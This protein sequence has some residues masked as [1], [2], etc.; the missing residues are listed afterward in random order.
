MNRWLICFGAIALS[1]CIGGMPF[2]STDV[3]KLSPVECV[4]IGK[5]G[6]QIK[7]ETDTGEIGMGYNVA[8]AFQNLRQTSKDN[9]FMETADCLLLDPRLRN[10]LPEAAE[11]L[12][13]G[14]S[15]CMEYGNCDLAD[16]ADF[17]ETQ[18]IDYTIRD[19]KAGKGGIPVLMLEKGRM[20]LEQP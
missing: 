13:P 1:V 3:G 18:E 15:I 2:E 14:C 10:V 17:L 6:N 7:A 12:R 4:R 11:L 20:R 5:Q 19:Y 9:V 8:E 16:A